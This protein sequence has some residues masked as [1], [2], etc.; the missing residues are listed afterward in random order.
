[1]REYFERVPQRLLTNLAFCTIEGEVSV[2]QGD[3]LSEP[4]R[5]TGLTG[6]RGRYRCPP[7]A[8]ESEE[9]ALKGPPSLR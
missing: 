2:D 9:W 5:G 8:P 7:E 4:G 3:P 6:R 1:M